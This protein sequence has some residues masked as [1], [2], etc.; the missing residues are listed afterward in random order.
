MFRTYGSGHAP[1]TAHRMGRLAI[2]AASLTIALAACGSGEDATPVTTTKP[3][4]SKADF[5]SQA[6]ALC[7]AAT[8]KMD[9][10]PLPSG[11]PTSGTLSDDDLAITA[12][13]LRSM[14]KIETAM[15]A[16]LVAL[17]PPS[18]FATKWDESM[19]G[20]QDRLDA[21]EQAADAAAAKDQQALATAFKAYDA[22]GDAGRA[23]LAGYGFKVCGVG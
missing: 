13:A 15:R 17:D 14:D 5:I 23:P 9:A 3:T 1:A 16:D 12:T 4:L 11:D 8:K 19:G 22:A 6:D 10:V 2:I 21:G 20:L 18:T 7:A